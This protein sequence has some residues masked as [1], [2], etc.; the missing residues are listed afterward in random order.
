[1]ET[2]SWSSPLDSVSHRS[3]GTL[4]H[5][6]PVAMIVNVLRPASWAREQLFL[7]P[8]VHG[9]GPSPSYPCCLVSHAATTFPFESVCPTLMIRE[10]GIP[11]PLVNEI[12]QA[13]PSQRHPCTVPCSR[14]SH[15]PQSVPE[16][17]RYATSQ[18]GLSG[19][20]GSVAGLS[21]VEGS[22]DIED[23]FCC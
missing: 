16:W 18:P 10:R 1:M 5:A 8:A 23:A 3:Q 19:A 22:E 11:S 13:V 9:F 12:V 7:E 14:S 6:V 21:G 17:S 4:E 20:V 2:P 15:P